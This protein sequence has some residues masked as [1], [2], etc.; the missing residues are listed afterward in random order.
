MHGRVR[1]RL[2]PGTSWLV[3][4]EHVRGTLD[5]TV[6]VD[7]VEAARVWTPATVVDVDYRG[8]D[9]VATVQLADGTRAQARVEG[10]LPPLDAACGVR[11]A[12]PC[13]VVAPGE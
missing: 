8:H 6:D 3:R 1:P 11:L 7:G 9:S 12:G 2:C 10:A 5:P 13:A 4:P